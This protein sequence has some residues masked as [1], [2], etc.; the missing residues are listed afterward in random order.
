MLLKIHAERA[1]GLFA[2]KYRKIGRIDATVCQPMHYNDIGKNLAPKKD[3]FP[4]G[5]EQSTV[6]FDRKRLKSAT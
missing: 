3:E 5:L 6:F 2:A 4:L 1:G